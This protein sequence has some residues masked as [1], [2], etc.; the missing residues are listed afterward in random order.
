MP[1]LCAVSALLVLMFSS[2]PLIGL[3]AGRFFVYEEAI[4]WGYFWTWLCLGLAWKGA[5]RP[6]Y[7]YLLALC[8]GFSVFFRPTLLLYGTLLFLPLLRTRSWKERWCGIVGFSLSPAAWLVTNHYR[9]GNALEFGHGLSLSDQ[10]LLNLA[11]KFGSPFSHE[12]LLS[13]A[14]ELL[15]FLF[16]AGGAS[17][18]FDFFKE[19]FFAGQSTTLRFRELYFFSYDWLMLVILLVAWTNTGL[20]ARKA[21]AM[22][23]P[24]PF[25]AKVG[26]LSFLCS[27]AQF[28]FYLHS[29]SLASRFSADFAPAFSLAALSL[30]LTLMQHPSARLPAL[31]A[32]IALHCWWATQ[33]FTGSEHEFQSGLTQAGPTQL[34]AEPLTNLP[35]SYECPPRELLPGIIHLASGWALGTD[36]TARGATP[37][38]FYRTPCIAIAI[39]SHEKTPPSILVQRER[40]SFVLRK[41]TTS[42]SGFRLLF[43]EQTPS[44][45]EPQPTPQLFWLAWSNPASPSRESSRFQVREITATMD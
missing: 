16:F 41:V 29:P 23:Q 38:F 40:E 24:L 17:N 33:G 30:L 44:R 9:F 39:E 42:P 18:G 6:S 34:I 15:G 37:L 45:L 35:K 5:S 13:A 3:L 19:H 10:P 21:F 31:T 7:F 27:T 14:R 43:C 4:A 25:E 28:L 22:R 8:S 2:P 12:S 1:G 11:L 20:T 26:V 36:C 32:L